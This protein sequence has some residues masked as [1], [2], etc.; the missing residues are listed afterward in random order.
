MTNERSLKVTRSRRR[1]TARVTMADGSIWSAPVG[2]PL[3]VYF[4]QVYPELIPPVRPPDA[5]RSRTAVAA[6][7]DGRLK[8]LTIPIER[9]V[10]VSPV[11]VRDSDGL[12]IY[13]RSLSFLLL[14]AAGELYP[15]RRITID[16]ALPFG[17]YYCRVFEGKPFSEDELAQIKARMQELVRENAPIVRL[18][19][20]LEEAIALFRERGDD[21][22]L[23]LMKNRKKDYLILYELCGVRNYFYGYMVPSTGYLTIFDLVGD[24]DGF[25]LRFPRRI[26]PTRLQPIT[27]LP[28]LRSVFMETA[29]WLELLGVDDVG[30]LNEAIRTGRTRE[31]IL[32]AEALHEGRFADI[33]DAIV[34]RQPDVRLVLIAGPS[35]SGKTTSSKRLA[36][37]LLAHGLK[38]FT[39]GL[40]DYFVD[41]EKTPRD[42]H[43]RF[44]F[45]HLH[46][47]DLELFNEQL[48]ALMDGEEVRLPHF[49]FITGRREWGDTVRLSPDHILIV[50]GIHGLNPALIPAIP[51]ER[52]F[53]LYVSCLTQ[54]NIDR[55]NRVPTTD[56]RLLRRMV[57]D[58]RFRGYSALD[59]LSH[60]P[61]VRQ[62]ER[63]WI[64]PY[65]ENA[66]IM[67]NSA[68][69]Y[70]LAVL[71]PKAE[72][73]LLQV[74]HQSPHHIEAK[75]LLSFLGWVEPLKRTDLI[76]DNSLLREF[77][78]E[79]ILRDYVPGKPD[80]DGRPG[81][82]SM[83]S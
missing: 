56:V 18:S 31:L 6:I 72:P 80:L 79:S 29:R 27:V 40:D 48:L 66:D 53:R 77:I 71:R 32:A 39:L 43:G 50:E 13:R 52:V 9:D 63:R 20:P 24:G 59:T 57:R 16:H 54:L 7:V 3:E 17:G 65:Q 38:P 74:A 4:K 30:A 45:E 5:D 34:E 42:E 14:V 82:E 8:E 47:V 73:L 35:A 55:H 64:F 41:R 2:T 67:F 62:G 12:R 1:R 51:P 69:V 78:G 60:W 58:A 19:V 28:K 25:I 26:D 68:L 49:N 22:K 37:Q 83:L 44:D 11:L 46:T 76:P 75:R 61:N 23:R 10:T 36:V 15:E 70:E 21:D 81:R 33:A